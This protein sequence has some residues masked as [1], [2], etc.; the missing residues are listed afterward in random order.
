MADVADM[1]AYSIQEIGHSGATQ[2]D[3]LEQV[4]CGDYDI[5]KRMF[6]NYQ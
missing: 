1:S 5:D 6:P 2:W 4:T 3:D